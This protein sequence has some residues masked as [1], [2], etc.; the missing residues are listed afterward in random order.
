MKKTE[1]I[2]FTLN[3]ILPRMAGAKF[4]IAGVVA[5]SML[6]VSCNEDSVIG[7][8]VQPEGDL[9][10]ARTTD[11]VSITTF[12]VKEDSV[13]TDDLP[14][15]TAVLGSYNDPVFGQTQASIYSQFLLP[16]NLTSGFGSN[17]TLDSV[18]L[19]LAYESITP[20]YG[21]VN[22]GDMQT[23]KV[24]QLTEALSKEGSYYSNEDKDVY[25]YPIG[26]ATFNPRPNPTDS[27]KVGSVKEKAQLRIRLDSTFG[28]MLLN[29][30]SANLGSNTTF[31]Q[32][33]KG[34]HIKPENSSQAP[35]EGAILYYNLLD[36]KSGVILYYKIGTAVQTPYRLVVNSSAARYGRFTHTY[37]SG[38]PVKSQ[39]S[40]P[41]LGQQQTYVQSLG[42]LK[43]K[44]QFP[45]IADYRD[46]G[47]VVNRA[48][49]VI[50]A[51]PSYIS[52]AYRAPE[53][54]F[55]VPVTSTGTN[56]DLLSWPDF[57]EGASYYGG[58]YDAAA[59]EYR[60]NISHYIQGIISGT[61]TDYGLYLTVSGSAVNASRLVIGGGNNAAYEMQLRLTYTK[62]N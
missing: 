53:K 44:L 33:F 11:T 39:L 2:T 30:G 6:V 49:L 57:G 62:L 36:A 18:V 51:D 54:L 41:A 50:K 55:I 4:F 12:T 7:L 24:Y 58:S 38:G 16:T 34:L 59:K 37:P 13:K 1:K 46:S 23:V 45:Y 14:S 5:A 43:T 8:D 48:E 17:L 29:A 52:T 26:S 61:V 60:F 15:G 20:Y 28:S 56:G 31:L 40:N 35:G 10:N 22:D 19:A 42:G 27:V 47:I 25:P 9:L 3:E 32:Y 21:S